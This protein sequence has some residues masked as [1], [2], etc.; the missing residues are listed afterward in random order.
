MLNAHRKES[1]SRTLWFGKS[2]LHQKAASQQILSAQKLAAYLCLLHHWFPIEE[3][4]IFFSFWARVHISVWCT[5]IAHALFTATSSKLCKYMSCKTY[6]LVIC[7]LAEENKD[8]SELIVIK[9]GRPIFLLFLWFLV[10]VITVHSAV[11]PP[12]LRH[13]HVDCTSNWEGRAQRNTFVKWLSQRDF[14][15]ILFQMTFG[16]QFNCHSFPN[17]ELHWGTWCQKWRNGQ[18]CHI[19][20]APFN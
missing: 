13:C 19:V 3:I 4:C 8:K 11:H 7:F 20:K 18:P 16:A 10:P 15:K 1:E 12:C 9:S 2:S 6:L 14:V 5:I 17:S